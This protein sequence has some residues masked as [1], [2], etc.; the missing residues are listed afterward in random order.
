MTRYTRCAV[1]VLTATLMMAAQAAD[2]GWYPFT[3]ARKAM[4]G[5]TTD[6]AAILLPVMLDANACMMQLDTGMGSS[7]LY[8][9]FLPRDYAVNGAELVITWFGLG[10]TVTPHS[11]DLMYDD[12][13]AH[14]ES[15]CRRQD[16]MALAGTVG[17]DL[18]ANGSLTLDLLHARFRFVPHATP[19]NGVGTVPFQLVDPGNGKGRI[20]LVQA[21]LA[22]GRAA[23]LLFDTGSAPAELVVHHEKDWLAVVGANGAAH[24]TG[25]TS[26]A[27]GRPLTCRTAPILQAVHLGQLVLGPQSHATFCTDAD[28][29]A[30]S[31]GPGYGVLGLAPFMDKTITLDYVQ[32]R[33]SVTAPTAP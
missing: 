28:G 8:R 25:M 19:A 6:H 32:R 33:L 23:P 10:A 3:W 14:R 16:G 1:L 22:D 11:F 27:W 5:M 12:D 29:R 18:F 20:V 17:N 7:V 15:G 26:F 9:P 4:P 30:Y 31:D 21:M 2:A 24:A 13:Q